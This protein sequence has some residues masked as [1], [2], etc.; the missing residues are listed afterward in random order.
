MLSCGLRP[1]DKAVLAELRKWLR[2]KNHWVDFRVLVEL[3]SIGRENLRES[4]T[5]LRE[6]GLVEV[7]FRVGSQ[8]GTYR[9]I[10]E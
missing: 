3:T 10:K 7:E 9:A 5:R 2:C 4:L 6:L 1:R 8:G